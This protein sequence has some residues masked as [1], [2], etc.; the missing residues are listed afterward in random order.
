MATSVTIDPEAWLITKNNTSTPLPTCGTVTGLTSSAITTTTATISWSATSGANNYDVDYK[1]ASSPT[2][3]NAA[4]ATA[5]L[6]VNLAGLTAGSLYDWRVKPNCTAP[7]GTYVQSQFTT[8]AVATC[9]TVTG[10]TSSAITSSAATISWSALAGANNYTVDYKLASS[11][12]WTSAATATTSLSINLSG[13]TAAS[14]YDWRVRANCTGATGAFAQ[15]QFTT[16]TATTCPDPSDIST[17]GTTSGAALISLNTDIK[18]R[19][20]P[21]NDIDNYRFHITTGGTITVT[22]QTLPANYNL[23]L[24]NAS[25]KRIG[26]SNNNGT[27]NET[28][29]VTVT[30]GDY[31]AQ[32]YPSG[33][34]N[35]AALC[36][37]LKITTGTASRSESVT[38]DKINMLLFPIPAK[39]ALNILVSGYDKEKIIEVFDISGK[40]VIIQRV[41]QDNTELPIGKLAS[42]IYI[43]KLSSVDGVVLSRNKFVKE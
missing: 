38:A 29:S 16:S 5:S 25:G 18:G 17:N 42:G 43:I 21:A 9:G 26:R 15:A 24:L 40:R 35:N 33:N 31:Y 1:L 20:S 22:L 14:L 6:S 19:I 30:T 28:I 4:T 12:T 11:G 23:D 32:V 34:A 2:W 27:N 8:S 3:I 10:L 39:E 7:T 37:T 13:L 41:K 36:Y